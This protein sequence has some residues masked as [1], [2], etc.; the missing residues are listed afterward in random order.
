MSIDV[1]YLQ[2]IHTT[3][4][5]ENILYHD[6]TIFVLHLTCV[7]LLSNTTVRNRVV[8]QFWSCGN[9]DTVIGHSRLQLLATRTTVVVITHSDHCGCWIQ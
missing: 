7:R 8:I 4:H 5:T 3:L 1:L 2:H 9:T 6:R